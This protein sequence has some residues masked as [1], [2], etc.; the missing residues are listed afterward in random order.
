MPLFCRVHLEREFRGKTRLELPKEFWLPLPPG[1][2]GGSRSIGGLNK[3][4]VARF[5]LKRFSRKEPN[6]LGS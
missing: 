6:R 2:V 3:W 4:Q 5:L 1:G